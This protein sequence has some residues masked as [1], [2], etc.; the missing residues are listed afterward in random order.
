MGRPHDLLRLFGEIVRGAD[1]V[2][3]VDPLRGPG[4]GMQQRHPSGTDAHGLD[5]VQVEPVESVEQRQQIA[6]GVLEQ[7]RTAEIAGPAVP[8]QI[9]RD[10]PE[11]LSEVRQERLSASLQLPKPWISTSGGPLP[12]PE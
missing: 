10:H 5:L 12:V 8:T 11:V 2:H 1:H 7:E 3:G 4:G 6:C 9:H